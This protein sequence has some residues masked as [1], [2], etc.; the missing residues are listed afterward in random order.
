LQYVLHLCDIIPV[1]T[2]NPGFGGQH[3]SPEVLPKIRG[4]RA[5][6]EERGLRTVIEV[7]GGQHPAAV[8]LVVEAGAEAIVGSSIFHSAH[9]GAAIAAIR[10]AAA[11]SSS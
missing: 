1:M 5:R 6:C 4:R 10:R 11:S 8:R 3:V 2:L 7:E 9:Y